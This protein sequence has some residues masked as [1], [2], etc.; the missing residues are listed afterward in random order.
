MNPRVRL[1][2]IGG[3]LIIVGL[4]LWLAVDELYLSPR[5]RLIRDLS[6]TQQR[7][8]EIEDKLDELPRV[9]KQLRDLAATTL[10]KEQDLV[11]HRFRSSLSG[12]AERAGLASIE[13]NHG[14]PSPMRNPLTTVARRSAT[15][16][17]R[18]LL[19]ATPD[20]QL[21]R[22]QVKGIGTLEQTLGLLAGLEAQPWIHRVEG[23]SLRPRK[24][25]EAFE[26]RADVLSAYLPDLV[27]K[28]ATEVQLSPPTASADARARTL[29]MR[30]PFREPPRPPAPKP[31]PVQ[32]LTAAP[33]PVPSIS[34]MAAYADYKLTGVVRS[35][36]G[37]VAFLLNTRSG[38]RVTL[39]S[40]GRVLDAVLVGG[41]GEKAVFEITG[42]TYEVINGNTLAARRIVPDAV[43]SKS[44]T[45]DGR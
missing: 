11:E 45:P 15:T 25:G 27:T 17:V 30:N 40:G 20:A 39:L 3:G 8:G 23:F 22:G 34:E 9:R 31:T 6:T 38:E 16:A 41:Q 43:H 4:T 12:L 5:A 36:Q 2:A 44:V 7:I 37:V 18:N 14:R 24:G 42:K 33:T 29:A 10:G 35:S 28:S 1:A 26:I 13:V 32:A 19:T 21:I